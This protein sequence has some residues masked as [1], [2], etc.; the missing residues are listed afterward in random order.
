[1]KNFRESFTS[2]WFPLFALPL[3]YMFNSNL[4]CFCFVFKDQCIILIHCMASIECEYNIFQSSIDWG[5]CYNF[6]LKNSIKVRTHKFLFSWNFWKFIR[7]Q[8]ISSRTEE[9]VIFIWGVF[10]AA[11]S[12]SL[13]I[14]C[15]KKLNLV[16]LQ[17][18]FW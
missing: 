6:I 1:M 12:L 3:T 9:V 4:S 7:V 8:F 16:S 2:F 14:K 17:T 15:W 18:F 10:S 11:S 13:L 5:L